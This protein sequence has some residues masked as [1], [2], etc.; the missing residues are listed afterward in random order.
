VFASSTTIKMDRCRLTYLGAAMPVAAM[1][2][3]YP[4]R[5]VVNGVQPLPP[6]AV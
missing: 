3:T 6:V 2:A 1:N 4:S 5:S